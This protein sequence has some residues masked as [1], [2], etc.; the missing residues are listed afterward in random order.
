[1]KT[2]TINTC[3]SKPIEFTAFGKFNLRWSPKR[4]TQNTIPF[5]E[6]EVYHN[7]TIPISED[8]EEKI[9]RYMKSYKTDI[10]SNGNRYYTRLNGGLVEVNH[11]KIRNKCS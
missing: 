8:E 5:Y 2:L 4:I 11:D 10:I 6:L 9:L 3:L 7:N 1:M